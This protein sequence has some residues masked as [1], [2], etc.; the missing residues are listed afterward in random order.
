V[1]QDCP[2]GHRRGYKA[3]GRCGR[4]ARHPE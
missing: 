2:L 3:A 1:N 4:H